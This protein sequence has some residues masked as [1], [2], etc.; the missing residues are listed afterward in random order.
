MA[1]HLH[2]KSF[3]VTITFLTVCSCPGSRTLLIGDHWA[4]P[5]RPPAGPAHPAPLP[6]SLRLGLISGR[7]CPFILW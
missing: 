2:L 4:A 6:T 5:S 7:F 1:K 3:V